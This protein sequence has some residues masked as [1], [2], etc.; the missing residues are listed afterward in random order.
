[1]FM[2]LRLKLSRIAKDLDNKERSGRCKKNASP[3]NSLVQLLSLILILLAKKFHAFMDF[4][5]S[6]PH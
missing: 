1:M 2:Y 4:E 6:S 3:R 5:G